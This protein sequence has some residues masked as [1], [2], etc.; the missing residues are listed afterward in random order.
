MPVIRAEGTGK[1]PVHMA[2]SHVAPIARHLPDALRPS[3]VS[4][5]IGAPIYAVRDLATH[6]LID[7]LEDTVASALGAP[8]AYSKS[9]VE[10]LIAKLK[11]A[12]SSARQANASR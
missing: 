12:S 4:I 11:E 7:Q 2:I 6:G 3:E 8:G 1:V 9:S 5:K 10:T